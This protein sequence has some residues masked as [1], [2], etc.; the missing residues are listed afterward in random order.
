MYNKFVEL[1]TN[2]C[3][4]ELSLMP[5]QLQCYKMIEQFVL[6]TLNLHSVILFLSKDFLC[7]TWLK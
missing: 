7:Y 3:W 1:I 6:S 5:S 4:V 2:N